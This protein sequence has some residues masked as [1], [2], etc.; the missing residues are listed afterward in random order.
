[1][2]ALAGG[3]LRVVSREPIGQSLKRANPRATDGQL[4]VDKV[5]LLFESG[6]SFASLLIPLVRPMP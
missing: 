2:A 4:A 6:A 5:L 1:M 3:V